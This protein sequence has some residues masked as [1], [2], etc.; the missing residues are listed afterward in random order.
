MSKP[1]EIL[2]SLRTFASQREWNL[3]RETV[4][5][6]LP[7][8]EQNNTLPIIL[9]P[10]MQFL[11]DLLSALPQDEKIPHLIALLDEASSYEDL[12]ARGQVLDKSLEDKSNHP[13]ILN[14][15]NALRK[16]TQ[17]QQLEYLSNAYLDTWVD[18]LSE[19]LV[20]VLGH[21][22]GYQNLEL[23]QQWFYGR[24]R[25]AMLIPG[26]FW[27]SPGYIA[28]EAALWNQVADDIEAAFQ[29]S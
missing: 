16:V 10:S 27:A 25:E 26:Y 4:R 8:L 22:W 21:A 11:Q 19:I 23:W 12:G 5:E 24:S 20:A 13:G 29:G 14:Y 17:L 15:R 28:L 9:H 2:L 18:I 3:C 7:L 6:M 1:Q